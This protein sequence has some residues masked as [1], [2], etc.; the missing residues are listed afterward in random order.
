MVPA[1]ALWLPALPEGREALGQ[2]V[3]PCELGQCQ[4]DGVFAREATGQQLVDAGVEVLRQLFNDFAL[5]RGREPEGSQ[6]PAQER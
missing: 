1:A 4:P 2:P 5:A 3:P 6:P